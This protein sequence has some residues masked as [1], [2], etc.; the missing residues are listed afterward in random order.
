[1]MTHMLSDFRNK[2][3]LHIATL[4]TDPSCHVFSLKYTLK[5]GEKVACAFSR[6]ICM[7]KL[8]IIYGDVIA[9]LWAFLIRL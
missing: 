4:D 5:Y 7:F 3:R 1:M 2:H 8:E 9:L 6:S